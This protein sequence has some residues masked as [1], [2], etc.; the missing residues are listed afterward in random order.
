VHFEYP[1]LLPERESPTT[2]FNTSPGAHDGA[3]LLTDE[4]G[5][6]EQTF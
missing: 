2:I 5:V 4:A 3:L 1:R 6:L